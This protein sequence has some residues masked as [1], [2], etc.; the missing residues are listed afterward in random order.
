MYERVDVRSAHKGNTNTRDRLYLQHRVTS[1]RTGDAAPGLNSSS[2]S[3][4]E[5]MLITRSEDLNTSEVHGIA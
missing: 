5:L 3:I 2:T 4:L 1:L